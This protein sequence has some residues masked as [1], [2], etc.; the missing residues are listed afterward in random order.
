MATDLSP[1]F[2]FLSQL[3]L[4]NDRTW[5]EAHRDDYDRAREAAEAF[6]F[7]LFPALGIDRGSHKASHWFFRIH[8]D[9]RF[10]KDK[11]PYKTNFG[12]VLHPGG[13]KAPELGT[14]LHLQ[15][16]GESFLAGGL[17]APTPEQLKKFRSDMEDGPRAFLAILQSEEFRARLALM[18]GDKLKKVPKGFSE[19]H[20]AAELL[21]LK[22]IVAWHPL[23]DDQVLGAGFADE[24][25]A[26]DRALKPFLQYLEEAVGLVPPA[27]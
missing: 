7:E 4:N 1:T 24:V 22:Q 11:S 16:G 21:K 26:T 2:S 9:A 12:C 8:R 25:L 23:T 3:T 18:E 20:P 14:Y 10:S 13:K 17:Y 5:F 6:V 27:E 15:P 19:D